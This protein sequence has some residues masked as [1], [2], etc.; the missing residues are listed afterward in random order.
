MSSAAAGEQQPRRSGRLRLKRPWTLRA[1]LLLALLLLSA[2]G[3]IAVGFTS[4]FLLRESLMQRV[5]EQL[6]GVSRP[7]RSG[8]E[9]SLLRNPHGPNRALPTNFRMAV[10]DANGLIDFTIP[11]STVGTSGPQ[12]P[13]LDRAK[14]QSLVGRPFS[15]PDVNG[16][17]DWQVEVSQTQSGRVVAVALSL[18]ETDDTVDKLIVIELVVGA[19]VLAVLA[20]V[21]T[22]VVRLGLRPLD[23]IQRTAEAIATGELDRRVDGGDQRTETGRLAKALN[24]MLEQL[25]A[26]MRARGRSEDRL[27]R[28]VSD[29]SHELRT[30]LTSIR[31]FAEL[32]RRGGAHAPEDVGRMMAR[33][34][35]EADR[36]GRLV[37]DL[38]LLAKLDE[39][40]A[41]DMTE[42]DVSALAAAAVQDA[43]VRDPSR[44]VLLSSPAESIRVL[45]DEHRLQQ[46][47]ANL[48]GNALTHTPAGTEVQVQ[49]AN[50]LPV[51]GM[52]PDAYAGA[53]VP[54]WQG[55]GVIEV[56]D[57]GPGI[58]AD[59][60]GR[61]FDRFYR[62][63]AARS[64]ARGGSGL[65]LSITAAIVAAH[66][67]RIELYG[68]PGEGARFRVLLPL[69]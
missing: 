21:A 49:V 33:I 31:G 30:P 19:T 51:N 55:V 47:L 28:F 1:R 42:V 7:W 64:R 58:P 26:A 3:L 69:A 12:L 23:R 15:V 10:F 61:V 2:V 25:G 57:S 52:V 16:G 56:A 20:V 40:R 4:V 35:N 8:H 18:A 5:N 32:Y 46:V 54:A 9:P 14:A 36:M 37:D 22:A 13:S 65:G 66:G 44:P 48:L 67:G 45:G 43:R 11:Q 60:A 38:L 39:Q 59:Q 34:E 50:A 29:A 41:L 27:R 62:V 63:D 24:S 68:G 17:S 53:E 6:N